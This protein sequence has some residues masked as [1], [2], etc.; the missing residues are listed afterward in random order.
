MMIFLTLA[1]VLLVLDDKFIVWIEVTTKRAGSDT[2][3][4]SEG[5]REMIQACV[6]KGKR[7]IGAV[8]LPV[9][10]E[11]RSFFEAHLPTILRFLVLKIAI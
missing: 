1:D 6:S 4:F 11:R 10:K 2:E 3:L 5:F 9:T 7:N 8:H